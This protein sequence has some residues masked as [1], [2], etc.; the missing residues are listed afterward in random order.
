MIREA[1]YD[2]VLAARSFLFK[3][4]H[5]FPDRSNKRAMTE[6]YTLEVNV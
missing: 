4:Y 2:K 1:T 3:H 5:Y 6:H